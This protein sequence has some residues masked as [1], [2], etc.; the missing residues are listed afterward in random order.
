MEQHVQTGL[1]SVNTV[2]LQYLCTPH[3]SSS[4]HS[5]DSSNI[6][7]LFPRLIEHVHKIS[8]CHLYKRRTR[9]DQGGSRPMKVQ[10][11][12]IFASGIAVIILLDVLQ[13]IL[14]RHFES[15]CPG[16][17]IKYQFFNI[18]PRNKTFLF[19]LFPFGFPLLFSFGR[20][21]C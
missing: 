21:K 11:V 7:T 14:V 18:K 2:S 19:L 1:E 13:G 20:Q 16:E 15:E 4:P 9:D 12:G 10:R 3:H 6:C 8:P 5:Y 17:V